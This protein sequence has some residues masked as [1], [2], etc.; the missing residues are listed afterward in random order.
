MADDHDRIGRYGGQMLFTAARRHRG[1]LGRCRAP[2]AVAARWGDWGGWR[3]SCCCCAMTAE[4]CV[5]TAPSL[6]RAAGNPREKL[7][8]VGHGDAGGSVGSR[9]KG[10][11]P[12]ARSRQGKAGPVPSS[13][14]ERAGPWS[15]CS[16]LPSR[17]CLAWDSAW[18][19]EWGRHR[20]EFLPPSRL[21]AER[22]GSR[23]AEIRPP[24]IA[25]E[26]AAEARLSL[27]GL[28]ALGA[29]SR[30]GPAVANYQLD[31]GDRHTKQSGFWPAPSA[32]PRRRRVNRPSGNDAQGGEKLRL[33]CK[34]TSPDLD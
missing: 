19:P 17:P 3:P 34:K 9:R 7:A 28:R 1:R 16:P 15:I 14:S 25:G 31:R 12:K 27:S 18:R 4:P 20:G 26:R 2:G 24:P 22:V 32:P 30:L 21:P 6:T 5:V 11:G 33:C 23:I 8:L 13:A 29:V 10:R